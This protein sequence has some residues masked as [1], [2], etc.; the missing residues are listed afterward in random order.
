M[1]DFNVNLHS[2]NSNRCAYLLCAGEKS[3]IERREKCEGI[4]EP[5]APVAFIAQSNTSEQTAL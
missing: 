2:N 4:G 3:K 1:S 5:V